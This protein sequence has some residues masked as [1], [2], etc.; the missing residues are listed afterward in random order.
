MPRQSCLSDQALRDK[1]HLPMQAAKLVIADLLTIYPNT[2]VDTHQMRGSVE[3]RIQPGRGENRRQCSRRRPFA[4]RACDENA[5]KTLLGMAQGCKQ[6]PHVRQVELVRWRL[7]QFVPERK[8]AGDCGF[9]GHKTAFSS[10][11]LA[12]SLNLQITK[13]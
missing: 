5:G 12:I 6:H 11:L 1:V 9:V 10:Q 3:S 8:H 4:V 2:L 13:G 7:R